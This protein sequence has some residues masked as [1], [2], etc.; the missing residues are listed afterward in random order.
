MSP[1]I[2]SLRAVAD[3][4][5]EFALRLQQRTSR[6]AARVWSPEGER[7]YTLALQ[8]EREAWKREREARAALI[9]AQMSMVL[10]QNFS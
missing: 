7:R 5:R 3:E 10:P 8:A 6:Y 2:E 4:R 1:L 9:R